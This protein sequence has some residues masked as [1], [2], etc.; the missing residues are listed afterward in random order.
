MNAKSIAILGCT[1]HVGKNLIFNFK[2][3]KKVELFLFSRNEQSTKKIITDFNLKDNFALKKYEQFNESEYD[4]IINC[5]GVSD[6]GKIIEVNNSILEITEKYDNLVLDYLEK[7]NLVN[8]VNFSSGAVYGG[9]FTSPVNSSTKIEIPN[10]KISPYTL[11]KI[12]SEIKHRNLKNFNIIDVRLFSF[13]SRYMNINTK[14]LISEIVS[15]IKNNKKFVTNK[16]DIFRDYINPEDLFNFIKI[17][18]NL[19][20]NCGLDAYSKESVSKFSLLEYLEEHFNLKYEMKE[21]VSA[22]SPTGIKKN[23]FSKSREAAKF[24]FIPQFTSIETISQ[25]LMYFLKPN[26]T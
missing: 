4:A 5:V 22:N 18:I 3:E 11:S 12:K 23:Y 2:K 10:Y 20:S 14:F 6:P 26:L 13:F 15:S 21:D 24:G 25:E 8:Y 19:N 16:I 9:D 1:G 17:C 7:H